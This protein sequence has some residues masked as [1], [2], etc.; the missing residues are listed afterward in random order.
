M[1]FLSMMESRRYVAPEATVPRDRAWNKS[2]WMGATECEVDVWRL[3]GTRGLTNAE[4][5]RELGLSKRTADWHVCHLLQKMGLN[6]RA[7]LVLLWIE[8]EFE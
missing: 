5:A 7:K 6:C 1:A 4:I 3:L 8:K 2:E